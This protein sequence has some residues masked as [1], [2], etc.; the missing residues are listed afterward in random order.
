[1]STPD[2]YVAT[3]FGLLSVLYGFFDGPVKSALDWLNVDV[4]MVAPVRSSRIAYVKVPKSVSPGCLYSQITPACGASCLI[5]S[6]YTAPL[7]CS[8]LDIEFIGERKFW[9]HSKNNFLDWILL[10]SSRFPRMVANADHMSAP[11]QPHVHTS[12]SRTQFPSSELQGS[13]R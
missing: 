8:Q 1:M 9:F 10:P 7:C 6:W 12:T 5:C 13:L 3:S 4:L 2:C 11:S